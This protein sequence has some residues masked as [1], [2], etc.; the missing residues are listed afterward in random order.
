MAD[1]VKDLIS[2]CI[3]FVITLCL[4]LFIP[5]AVLMKAW[6]M[7]AVARFNLPKFTFWEFFWVCLAIQML[8]KSSI[9]ISNRKRT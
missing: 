1:E 6:N 7:I 9:N 2:S 8:F 3:I 4:A 5:P